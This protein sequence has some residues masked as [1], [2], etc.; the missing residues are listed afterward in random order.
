MRAQ[1]ANRDSE[2]RMAQLKDTV[3]AAQKEVER[4]RDEKKDY[5]LQKGVNDEHLGAANAALKS[6]VIHKD[7]E[8][9]KLKMRLKWTEEENA[10]Q[11]TL[12]N[13]EKQGLLMELG[14]QV[15]DDPKRG[16]GARAKAGGASTNNSP[17]RSRVGGGGG[18]NE[19]SPDRGPAGAYERHNKK[20]GQLEKNNR[21]NRRGKA[22]SE[23][24]QHLKDQ[25][26]YRNRMG[27][28]GGGG[29]GGG[30]GGGGAP[31]WNGIKDQDDML[32]TPNW[33]P[34]NKGGGG[35]GGGG[36]RIATPPDAGSD[37]WQSTEDQKG[38]R[39]QDTTGSFYKEEPGD[40]TSS[41]INA[42]ADYLAKKKQ[43]DATKVAAEKNEKDLANNPYRFGDE[44]NVEAN[45]MMSQTGPASIGGGAG[46]PGATKF[47]SIGR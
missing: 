11:V 33:P 38:F 9:N 19:N 42:A 32:E 18:S 6:H 47:P 44:E 23:V 21:D 43:R 2:R 46:S 12:L 1:D 37:H 31:N 8:I 3:K 5:D 26:E 45:V 28:D 27:E 36:T 4:M 29:R 7:E 41:T 35:Q 30:G 25:E 34:G 40:T 17:E 24:E 14:L 39:P 16:A 10:S 15:G 13:K 22:L 20:Q